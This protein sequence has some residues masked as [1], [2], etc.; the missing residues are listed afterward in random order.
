M[1][2]SGTECSV[3]ENCRN[4][5]ECWQCSE[6][7][8]YSPIDKRILSPSV[9]E[10]RALRKKERKAKKYTDP[11]KRGRS[12]RRNGRRAEKEVLKFL[13]KIGLDAAQVP[14]SGSLKATGML[15]QL[16]DKMAGDITLTVGEHSLRVECKRNQNNNRWFDL[17]DKGVCI[18]GFC[19]ILNEEMFTNF[20]H[21]NVH[22]GDF[23]VMKD[24]GFKQ[25]HKYFE[26][27]NSD[28]VVVTKPYVR[29]IYFISMLAVDKLGGCLNDCNDRK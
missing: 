19:Y 2:G 13:Q 18:D 25:V 1:K 16:V 26:Q 4:K 7:R 6:Y 20:L 21:G 23:E 17:A 29:P 14:M 22:V 27:D 11:V 10:K 15:P 3:R 8:L 24:T 28:L 5:W 12:N 9:L